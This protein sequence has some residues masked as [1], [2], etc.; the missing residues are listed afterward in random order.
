MGDSGGVNKP[1]PF[2]KRATYEIENDI[3]LNVEWSQEIEQITVSVTMPSDGKLAIA[4]G[5]H[6]KKCDMIL[7]DSDLLYSYMSD[8]TYDNG[9]WY[10]DREQ[11]WIY[12]ITD[13]GSRRQKLFT[14]RR[15][16]DT[17]HEGDFVF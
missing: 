4:L 13:D 3:E 15:T 2:S 7:F 11:D 10:D 9:S 17:S 14:A 5:P 8:C 6:A 12:D 1:N 16:L